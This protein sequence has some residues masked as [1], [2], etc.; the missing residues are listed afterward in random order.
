M[1]IT[2]ESMK[3]QSPN[4]EGCHADTVDGGGAGQTP[5]APH[6][7]RLSEKDKL[8]SMSWRDRLWYIWEYYKFH[9]IGAAVAAV[10]IVSLGGAFYNSTFDTVLHCIYLNS[11]AATEVNPAPLEQDFAEYLNLGKKELITAE[12]SYISFD[13]NA[14]DYSYA[15]MAKVTA[16][17]AAHDLDIIIGDQAAIDHYASLNGFI[18]LEEGLPPD[19]LAL[20]KDRLYIAKDGE[21]TEYACAV[22]L[23]GT[24][25]AAASNLAQDPPLLG[26]ISNTENKDTVLQLIRYL[27]QP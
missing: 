25:F 16:L 27:F 22:D 9:I 19:V 20:V 24:E 7:P 18:N 17:V 15:A 26:I 10:L 23:S 12:I 6:K 14:T 3:Q 1:K 11:R 8:K 13:E 5:K 4:A 21:N 2:E